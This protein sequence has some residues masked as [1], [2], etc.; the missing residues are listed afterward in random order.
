[1]K[2]IKCKMKCDYIKFKFTSRKIRSL[3][4]MWT[5]LQP[6]FYMNISLWTS[7][8]EAT[9][10]PFSTSEAF[11]DYATLLSKDGALKSSQQLQQSD[12]FLDWW[13]YNQISSRYIFDFK[14]FGFLNKF[15]T[16]DNI[17]KTG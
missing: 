14:T 8:L 3:I 13:Q 9:S 7:L 2:Y 12:I 16:F 15:N 11:L 5:I 6:L 4:K 1:M 17:L 10:A